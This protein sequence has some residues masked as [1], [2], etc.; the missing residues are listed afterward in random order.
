MLTCR[1]CMKRCLQTLIGES[2]LAPTSRGSSAATNQSR[3]NYSSRTI[4]KTSPPGNQRSIARKPN[5]TSHKPE[6]GFKKGAVSTSYQRQQWLESRGVTPVNKRVER[7]TDDDL[8]MKKQLRYLK[9][10]LKLAAHV[11][12]VLRDDD[13]ESALALVRAASKDTQ[14]VVSWNH[15]IDWQLSR[16]KMNGAIKT[17]N[18]VVRPSLLPTA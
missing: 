18:E 17:Y 3:R 5:F 10:P 13:C 2:T 1:A 4:Q 15:I 7:T 14:C 11:R 12:Q 6:N 16:Q 9:D 8:L